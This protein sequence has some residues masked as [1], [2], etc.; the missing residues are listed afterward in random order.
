MSDLIKEIQK[1]LTNSHIE[2]SELLTHK[3]KLD[4]EYNIVTTEY[5]HLFQ[6][7]EARMNENRE[8]VVKSC[9]HKYSRISEYHNDRYFV[10]DL[11]GHEKY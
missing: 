2:S 5:R 3:K 7:I 10:C 11:C 4:E 6:Q 8:K 9:N 1:A